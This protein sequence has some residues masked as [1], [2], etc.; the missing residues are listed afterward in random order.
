MGAEELKELKAIKKLLM[1][2]L[3]K[4]GATSEELDLA[5]GMGAANVRRMLPTA[6][7]KK[8]SWASDKK[9]EK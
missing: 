9:K 5:T 4:S 2:D 8:Y 7:I 3:I 1:L 6:K